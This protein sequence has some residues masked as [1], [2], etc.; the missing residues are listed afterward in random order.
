MM[1]DLMDQKINPF[2]RVYI[3]CNGIF[4]V[5]HKQV[6]NANVLGNS[7]KAFLNYLLLNCKQYED[8]YQLTD[9]VHYLFCPDKNEPDAEK[10]LKTI[11]VSFMPVRRSDSLDGFFHSVSRSIVNHDDVFLKKTGIKQRLT[12]LK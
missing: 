3:Y 4:T 9:K 1:N 10:L 12:I 2:A 6:Y 7:N 11:C 8:K 5:I